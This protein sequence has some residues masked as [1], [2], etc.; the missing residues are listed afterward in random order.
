MNNIEKWRKENNLTQKQFAN[1]VGTNQS[2]VCKIEN[3][4]TVNL[5]RDIIQSIKSVTGFSADEILGLS[6]SEVSK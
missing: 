1:M 4:E 6:E 5:R 3:G 2:T